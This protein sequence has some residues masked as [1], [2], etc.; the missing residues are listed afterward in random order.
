MKLK[1]IRRLVTILNIKHLIDRLMNKIIEHTIVAPLGKRLG[2]GTYDTFWDRERYVSYHDAEDHGGLVVVDF[3]C[4]ADDVVYFQ[5]YPLNAPKTLRYVRLNQQH[6]PCGLGIEDY[7]TCIE[8]V[9]E[10]FDGR[11]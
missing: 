8:I 1:Y 4:D 11:I 7:F 3:V 9:S 5:I 6:F 2:L 10:F